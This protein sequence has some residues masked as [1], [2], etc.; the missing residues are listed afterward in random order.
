MYNIIHPEKDDVKAY[1][2]NN[3]SLEFAWGYFA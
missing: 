1:S 3:N 2:N